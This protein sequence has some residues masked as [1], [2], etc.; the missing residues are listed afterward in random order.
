MPD[1]PPHDSAEFL[2]RKARSLLR[3]ARAGDAAALARIETRA[4]DGP[5]KLADALHA[6]AREAGFESWPKLKFAAEAAAMDRAERAERLKRALYLGQHWVVRALLDADPT[7]GHE[8]LGLEC[9]LYDVAAVRDRLAADPAAA[10][11]VVGVR[12]PILHLSFSRH[13]QGGGSEADMLATAEALL[14]AGAD[15]N[16]SYPFEEGAE[17]RLSALYGAI[18]HAQNMTM[19]RW[20]LEHGADPND[21]E[22]LYHAT[23]LDSH[24]GL[25]LLIAHGA[26]PQG[27]NALPRA[28]DFDDYVA[29]EMLLDAGADPNEGVVRH[30]SGEPPGLVPALHQAARRMCSARIAELLLARGADPTARYQGLTPYAFARI[31]GNRPVAAVLERAG[32]ATPLSPVEA[33]LARAADDVT[34]ERDWIDMAK[35]PEELRLLLTRL[36]WRDGTLPHIRRLVSMGFDANQPDE[37]GMTP[38]HLAGWEGLVEKTAYFLTL[39]PDLGHVNAYGGTFFSTIL[40]GSENCPRRAERDHVGCM[41][42][43]LEHGVALPRPAIEGAADPA[44]AAFLADWAEAHPGAVV[45]DGVW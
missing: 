26:R 5:P 2:R 4:G 28:L 3:A 19:A 23:E 37:M 12:A 15:V 35:L 44:M 22:S 21:N 38:L 29:V 16:A 32:A 43:A 8:N 33:Q 42:L 24:E 1:L 18:G 13:W 20:L 45:D 41:R 27:T 6:L 31:Y 14:A 40:H 9:A 11:R 7:L 25:R 39:Q 30:P 36:V 34:R 17:H 10:N